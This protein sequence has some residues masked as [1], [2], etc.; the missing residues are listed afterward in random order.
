MSNYQ[1][2]RDAW[3]GLSIFEQ[4]GN[5]YAEVGRTLAAKRRGD[6]VAAN[7]AA[8]RAFD[9]FDATS[10]ELVDRKSPKLH[11]IMRAREQF[12]GEFLNDGSPGIEHYLSHFAIAARWRQS[13]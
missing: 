5:I 12:A 1:V 7:A 8:I 9:L 10:E 2:N 4:M 6:T 3:R 11:E 13:A